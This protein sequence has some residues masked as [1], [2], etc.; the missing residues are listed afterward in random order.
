MFSSLY[1]DSGNYNFCV[2]VQ[3]TGAIVTCWSFDQQGTVSD[4]ISALGGFTPLC[5]VHLYSP[6]CQEQFLKLF[7]LVAPLIVLA[8]VVGSGCSVTPQQPTRPDVVEGQPEPAAPTSPATPAQPPQPAMPI[9]NSAYAGLLQRAEEARTQGDYEQALALL[10]RA[11][12][13]DPGSAEIYLDM[14]RT[15]SARGDLDQ[16]RATAQRGLLYCSGDTQCSAL[17]GYA[18]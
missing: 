13:I 1:P 14:A 7:T 15:H 17:R 3:T 2:T 10:Q 11:H 6:V 4:E 5:D 9:D 16:A 12:R 18:N 8:I